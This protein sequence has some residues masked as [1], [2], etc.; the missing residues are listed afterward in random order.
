MKVCVLQP[1]YSTTDVDYKNYD[2]VRDLSKLLPGHTVHTVLLN[3]LTTYKQLKA[4]RKEGYDI[5]VNLCEGYLDWSVPSIDVIHSLDALNLPYTGPTALLYDPPK[6]LMKYVATTVGVKTPDFAHVY[7][8]E[9]LADYTKH[10]KFPMFV[11]PTKAG[12]SLGVD[13]FSLVRDMAALEKKV[14]TLVEQDYD[15]ILIEDY[16]P[17]REFTVLVVANIN[18]PYGCGSLKPIEY[19]FPKGYQFKTYALKTSELHTDVNK[20][21]DDPDLEARLR[22]SAEKIFNGFGGQGYARMDFR[23]N[24]KG[25]IYFLEINFTCS[26][27]YSEGMEGSADYIL[28]NDPIGKHGFLKHII[29]DGIARHAA[30]QKKYRVRADALHGYGIVAQQPLK[31]GDV[32]FRLEGTPQRIITKRYVEKYWSAAQLKD[33]RHYAY[34][35]SDKVFILWDNDPEYWAPQNHSCEPNTA[36]DGLNLVATRDIRLDEELTLDYADLLD[37]NLQPFEC[38]CGT[39]NCRKTVS[40]T[41]GNSITMREMNL[42]GVVSQSF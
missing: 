13:D 36:Y 30:K 4:L 5:F 2:P 18:P 35:I 28:N 26:V 15:D 32:I 7:G 33:F 10:L 39:P 25:E 34:P 8:D 6:T 37:E 3:K 17:G 41:P 23:V 38:R 19:K 21:I 1:D 20:P 12:D 40:G 9:D 14:K 24:E 29:A 31:K 27:F 22:R 42:S 11:K 16:I